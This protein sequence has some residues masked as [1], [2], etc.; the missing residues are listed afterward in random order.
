MWVYV[1]TIWCGDGECVSSMQMLITVV[2]MMT[3]KQVY[4]LSTAH[5]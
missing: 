4:A 1:I 5:L 3:L 2:V